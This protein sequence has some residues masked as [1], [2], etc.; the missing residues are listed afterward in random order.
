MVE[1]VEYGLPGPAHLLQHSRLAW[2]HHTLRHH[3]L[4]NTTRGQQ[5]TNMSQH[6][7]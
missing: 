3:P 5:D 2:L 1:L 6:E 7:E 4:H